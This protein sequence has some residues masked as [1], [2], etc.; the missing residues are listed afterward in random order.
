MFRLN[1]LTRQSDTLCWHNHAGAMAAGAAISTHLYGG[2]WPTNAGTLLVD[3]DNVWNA[4]PPA[5][6]AHFLAARY[7]D[8]L[9]EYFDRNGPTGTG[10]NMASTVNVST[11]FNNA[12]YSGGRVGYGTTGSG[13]RSMAGAPDIV[14][15][16]WS[17][18]IT[19]T[20]SNLLHE[21]ESGALSEGFSDV[22]GVAFGFLTSLDPDWQFGENWNVGGLADHDLSNPPA[23]NQPDFY[24]GTNWYPTAGCTPSSV[25][26]YCGV[27]TNSG[28]LGKF[29]YLLSQGG[30]AH[31]VTV[32]GL[33]IANAA[34]VIYRANRD[35]WTSVTDYAG[36]RA[37]CIAAAGAIN[38]AWADNV[39]DAWAAVGVG[40]PSEHPLACA[41]PAALTSGVAFG[42][43]TIGA[44]RNVMDYNGCPWWESGPERVHRITLTRAA[45]LVIALTNLSANL[46]L[47]LLSACGDNN[48]ITYGDSTI[49]YTAGPG[50]Y[51]IVVDGFNGAEGSYRLM[52]TA[53]GTVLLTGPN[54]GEVWYTGENRVITW[55]SSL[56][57]NLR[58]EIDRG[59]PSTWSPLA[60]SVSNSGVYTWLVTGPVTTNARIRITG[61]VH[62]A[63]G[64]TSNASFA[65]ATRRLQLTSPNGG[66]IWAI[67]GSQD[68]TWIS[69]G[70]EA[71]SLRIE[72]KRSFPAGIWEP[73]VARAPNTGTFSWPVLG[74]ASNTARIRILGTVHT[75]VSDTSDANFVLTSGGVNP[76]LCW[77][78]PRRR[79]LGGQQ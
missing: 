47:F 69:N 22:M 42:G 24:G 29:Y 54:G 41:N 25:N 48:T 20:E 46:D 31:G 73:L 78:R 67:G 51:Y 58:L 30:T 74:T 5:V 79:K 32:S 49:R 68:I 8:F 40:D 16:E 66:E 37:G 26:D 65:I 44:P 64:D 62:P 61:S 18:G 19:E 77:W 13:H 57:E 12:A 14:G 27:H 33:G 35:Y 59:Y 63:V 36:A 76:T 11:L 72:L 23:R 9:R 45:T 4:N 56:T 50:T 10:A 17:H 34:N 21:K 7:Y 60:Y 43:N 2:N 71:E 55:S 75:G 52:A 53:V 15:H 28:V 70:M 3:S 39:R 6:D 1:D 38:A